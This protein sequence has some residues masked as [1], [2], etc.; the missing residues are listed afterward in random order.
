MGGL[1]GITRRNAE[2]PAPRA[3]HRR[4]R[5]LGLVI[6]LAMAGAPGTAH[7]HG[8]PVALD[9]WGGYAPAEA[10]CQRVVSRAAAGCA[11]RA[12]AVRTACL[13]ARLRGEACDDAAADAAVQA[14][15]TAARDRVDRD[16]TDNQLA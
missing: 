16:C 10:G 6:V 8:Q 11:A 15:R 5:V 4:L 14:V 7:A 13:T 1:H 3:A 12:V 9:F 2:R